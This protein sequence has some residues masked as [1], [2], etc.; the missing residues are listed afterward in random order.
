MAYPDDLK[1]RSCMTLFAQ[2]GGDVQ[3]FVDALDK[4][5]GGEPDDRT[6]EILGVADL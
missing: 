5:C 3:V 6:L 1:F 2:A 4:Y